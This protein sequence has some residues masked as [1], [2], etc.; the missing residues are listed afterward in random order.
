[1]GVGIG[2]GELVLLALILCMFLPTI[3]A[4]SLV[5]KKA[6]FSRWWACLLLLPVVNLVAIWVF[7]FIRW[8]ALSAKGVVSLDGGRIAG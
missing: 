7:A 4:S 5:L 8:P 1:M 3:W 6:G 2:F